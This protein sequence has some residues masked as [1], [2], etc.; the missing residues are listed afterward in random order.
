MRNPVAAENSIIPSMPMFTTPER[1][2][3]RPAIAPSAIGV[4]RASDW[5]RSCIT[6]VSG[7]SDSAS[8]RTITRGTS[9][10]VEST[11]A[12][13]ARCGQRRSK[14]VATAQST[15]IVPMAATTTAGSKLTLTGSGGLSKVRPFSADSRL[16][17]T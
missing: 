7:A 14:N 6:F 9:S 8:D 3:Q 15:K 10:T 17:A 13:L 11:S 1:S 2:H 12:P 16:P 4:P 5:T